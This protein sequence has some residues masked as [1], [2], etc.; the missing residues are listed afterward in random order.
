MMSQSCRTVCIS[1]VGRTSNDEFAALMA[2]MVRREKGSAQRFFRAVTPLLIAFYGGQV[3]A[4]RARV[5][6]L[7]SLVQKALVEV[8]RSRT[9]NVLEHRPFRAWL[10]DI[11]R[12]SMSGYHPAHRDGPRTPG[13]PGRGIR[14]ADADQTAGVGAA[15]YR[16]IDAKQMAG[17]N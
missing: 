16:D 6:D 11:A 9:S 14:L 3:Q 8:Y 7:E 15:A 13:Q 10:L 12:S 4:G 2:D 5:D 1:E 17:A